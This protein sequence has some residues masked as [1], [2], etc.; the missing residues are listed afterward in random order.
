MANESRSGECSKGGQLSEWLAGLAG[1]YILF[2]R[3]VPSLWRA[4]VKSTACHHHHHH[5]TS[6]TFSASGSWAKPG[7]G[8]SLAA[9]VA[10]NAA[11]PAGPYTAQTPRALHTE[12]RWPD[13]LLALI[14]AGVQQVDQ[15]V[16]PSRW[17]CTL[18]GVVPPRSDVCS[19]YSHRSMFLIAGLIKTDDQRE[20]TTR[21]P[22][23]D[24]V[25]QFKRLKAR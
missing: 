18:K 25:I 21:F 1:C 5:Q 10:Q 24:F 11:G 23:R 2:R 17:M 12:R 6:P 20:K 22:A 13:H 19:T 9:A 15:R 16:A 14:T 7:S 8:G 3:V 4:S